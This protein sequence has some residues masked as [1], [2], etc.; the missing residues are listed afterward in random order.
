MNFKTEKKV[1]SEC[2][3]DHLLITQ[4]KKFYEKKGLDEP[5]KCSTCRRKR[6]EA[7]RNKRE[8]HARKCDKCSMN[9]M[10]TYPQDSRYTVYCEQCYWDNLG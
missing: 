10:S 3:K 5:Q 6:R 9:L 8:L 1:C 7:L 4:E 2:K